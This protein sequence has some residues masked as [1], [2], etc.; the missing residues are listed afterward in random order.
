MFKNYFKKHNF[1]VKNDAQLI[2]H[3]YF[4]YLYEKRQIGSVTLA[5]KYW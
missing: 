5:A 4:D 3:N 2:F 1:Y